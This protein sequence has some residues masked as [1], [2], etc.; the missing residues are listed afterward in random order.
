MKA[1]KFCSS[2]PLLISWGR[3]PT[4]RVTWGAVPTVL[5]PTPAFSLPSHS[6]AAQD[7]QGPDSWCSWPGGLTVG[8]GF[9]PGW[10]SACDPYMPIPWEM[11]PQAWGWRPNFF[12]HPGISLVPSLVAMPLCLAALLL[13]SCPTGLHQRPEAVPA[14]L[15]RLRA[16]H[17]AHPEPPDHRLSLQEAGTAAQVSLG[18]RLGG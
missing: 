7:L 17:P 2:V 14:V 9:W 8:S 6:P 3:L 15:P 18:V 11:E 10:V 1:M 13:A 16:L 4:F 5:H 12:P